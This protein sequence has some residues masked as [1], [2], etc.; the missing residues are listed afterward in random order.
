M[1]V[2]KRDLKG[3][4]QPD[5]GQILRNAQGEPT[6]VFVDAAMDLVGAKVPAPRAEDRD[7]AFATA[8]QILFKRI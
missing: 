3:A 8:Q 1:R 2:A 7:V 4:W 5:G 6:G